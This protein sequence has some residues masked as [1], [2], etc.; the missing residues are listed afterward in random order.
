MNK[1]V[2][3]TDD[4]QALRLLKRLEAGD[5]LSEF[6]PEFLCEWH[7]RIEDDVTEALRPLRRLA[8]T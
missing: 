3:L 8:S 4:F 5:D 6:E 7:D 1:V 2:S